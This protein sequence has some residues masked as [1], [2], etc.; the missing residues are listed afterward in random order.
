M[1]MTPLFS[2]ILILHS[3]SLRSYCHVSSI[4]PFSPASLP[5]AFLLFSSIPFSSNLTQHF[6]F[7]FVSLYYSVWLILIV[8]SPTNTR[9]S[10]KWDGSLSFFGIFHMR[11]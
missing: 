3:L 2:S 10:L 4:T 8:F 5:H 1:S 7:C 6:F 9:K 11:M